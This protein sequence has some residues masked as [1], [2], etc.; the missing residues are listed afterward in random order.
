MKKR[1]INASPEELGI[2]RLC[3]DY[4]KDNDLVLLLSEER[5]DPDFEKD[6]QDNLDYNN[7]ENED[8]YER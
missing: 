2:I 1:W 8:E 7:E 3:F 4:L 6:N 5:Y